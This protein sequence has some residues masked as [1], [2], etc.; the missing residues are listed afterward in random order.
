[1]PSPDPNDWTL[2]GIALVVGGFLIRLN[3]LLTVTLAAYATGL[4]SKLMQPHAPGVLQALA[5][6][7]AEGGGG[8]KL[9]RS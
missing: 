2:I 6:V 4:I 7:T 1:M 9:T 3:P 5:E 8:G